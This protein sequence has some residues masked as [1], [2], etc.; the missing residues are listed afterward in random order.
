MEYQFSSNTTLVSTFSDP[1]PL[2]FAFPY[3]QAP[4]T[5][6]PLSTSTAVDATIPEY[7]IGASEDSTTI[8][9][10]CRQ[11]ISL[12]PD[13]ESATP[14]PTPVLPRPGR[15]SIC[16][17][18]RVTVE[19]VEEKIFDTSLMLSDIDATMKKLEDKRIIMENIL[20]RAQQQ[21]E[22][23]AMYFDGRY[24]PAPDRWVD[25]TENK[26]RAQEQWCELRLVNASVRS[27]K[28]TIAPLPYAD[29]RM[30]KHF[31]NRLA[32]LMNLSERQADGLL[33]GYG[34]DLNQ[35]AFVDPVASSRLDSKRRSL[36]RFIGVDIQAVAPTHSH[37]PTKALLRANRMVATAP[38]AR[39]LTSRF[40]LSIP[41]PALQDH[42]YYP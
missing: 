36:A 27:L 10:V 38:R 25:V 1:V 18:Q 37:L 34:Q 31:P 21:L 39:R 9:P 12:P 19:E 28:D 17:R 40:L 3:S 33:F 8:I 11:A 14:C 4:Q 30:P 13:L 16:F 42:R 29:G 32:G 23:H 41:E 35:R 26:R 2:C 5:S 20:D 24:P 6:S 7:P 22:D 15:R